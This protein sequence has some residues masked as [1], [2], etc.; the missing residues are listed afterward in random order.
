MAGVES[1]MP[2]SPGASPLGAL[3]RV[4]DVVQ[5]DAARWLAGL[6]LVTLASW[7]RCLAT[8]SPRVDGNYPTEGVGT[9]LLLVLATGW[10][11]AVVGW[12]GLLAR[13]PGQPRRLIYLGLLAVV[14]M[15]PLLSNDLFSLLA[16]ASLSAQGKDVFTSAG[17]YPQSTWYA[18][19]GERWKQ[20]PSPYGPVTLLAAWPS[21]LGGASAF[22]AEAWLKVA[23]LLPLVALVELSLRAFPARPAFHA[24]L[25]LNPLL[26][27]EGVGQLH[28]DLLGLL[29]VT[30]GILLARRSPGLGSGMAWS[31]A[32]LSKL[33]FGLALPWFWLHG[34]RE[35][36]ARLR[37]SGVLLLCF[38]ASAVLAY[39]PFWRGPETV[40]GQLRGLRA[41]TLVAGGTLAD[42]VGTVAGALAGEQ[43]TGAIEAFDPQQHAVRARATQLTQLLAM[44]LA[45]AAIVPLGLGLLRELNED[46]L[47]VATG[48]F[49]V[50]VATLAS[51]RFQS[52]YLLAALPFFALRCPEA[53]RR[54]WPWAA[55]TSVAPEMA[56][57]LPRTAFLF[58]PWALTTL[59]S[60]AVFFV[61]F[62]ARY[63]ALLPRAAEASAGARQ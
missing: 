55:L 20:S 17:A 10:A 60:V 44:L 30:A 11:L 1:E 13:P 14:P 37:R 21:V 23:W 6:V 62:R 29:L 48:A 12:A 15:L 32:T 35:T 26:L 9:L 4:R 24:F 43:G 2:E 38:A 16:Q 56:N 45:L 46:R 49:I 8:G 34:T 59:A 47:A 36:S 39:A 40:L 58:T 7:G 33:I 31:L 53:W 61:W 19:I 50:A 5:S 63:W 54:W 52:W 51:P 18:W 22:A 57:V 42:V 25:W 3:L 28:P 41:N 27:V